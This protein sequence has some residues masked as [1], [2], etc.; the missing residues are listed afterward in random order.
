MDAVVAIMETYRWK[1]I[2]MAATR[3]ETAPN[4]VARQTLPTKV[5]EASRQISE[6]T[7]DREASHMIKE[8]DKEVGHRTVTEETVLHTAIGITKGR[9]IITEARHQ[10]AIVTTEMLCTDCPAMKTTELWRE[11]VKEMN[12]CG[13]QNQMLILSLVFL[14]WLEAYRCLTPGKRS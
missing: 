7:T 2:D 14:C 5:L 4:L 1:T 3:E 9:Q 12:P 6:G 10:M 13:T 11:K 8:K